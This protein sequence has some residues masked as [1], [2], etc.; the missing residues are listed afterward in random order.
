[1]QA[2]VRSLLI[3]FTTPL[4]ASGQMKPEQVESWE[5][6]HYR[7]LHLLPC[8]LKRGFIVNLVRNTDP[9]SQTVERLA[10]K[11]L[12]QVNRQQQLPS[13]W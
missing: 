9:T 6:E 12:N 7:K 5:R 4:V 13:S 3:Y 1:M 8:D 11:V 10:R 2:Y